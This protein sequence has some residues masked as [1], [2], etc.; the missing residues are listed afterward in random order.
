MVAR[1][2]VYLETLFAG[3]VSWL[4]IHSLL[5]MF[6]CFCHFCFV[7][8]VVVVVVVVNDDDNLDSYL[9]C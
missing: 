4:V 3:T 2:G 8:F 9:F 1:R 5:L 7:E 6:I